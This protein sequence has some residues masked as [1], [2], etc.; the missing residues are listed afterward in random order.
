MKLVAE[1]GVG[2]VAAGVAKASADNILISGHDGGTGA[3]PLSSTKHAGAPWELGLAEAQ[4]TLL[5]NNLRDRVILRTDGGIRNGRDVVIAAILGAEQ[6]NFGTTAM[7]AM[8]CVYVRKCHLNTCPVGIATTDPKFRAKFKG[9]PEMVINYFDAVADEARRIMARLGVRSLDE[10]IGRPGFPQATPHPRSPESQHA[11][12]RRAAQGRRAGSGGAHPE[13]PWIPFL[14]RAP[15]TATTASPRPPSTSRSSPTSRR[16]V[17]IDPVDAP[18]Y[19]PDSVSTDMLDAIRLL[20]DRPPVALEY[21]VVNTDRNIGTRLSGR[22]AEI[23]GDRGL[24]Q[25]HDPPH[26]PRQRRPVASAVSS[27]P[28]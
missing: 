11:R 28:A 25:G 26:L 13:K 12:P 2:T 15:R 18:Q 1:S 7:I 5:L 19:G 3:S 14:A 23:H 9:T 6:Y 20:P 21:A 27:F 24:P 17:G 8:G 16:A 10:L 4:Q 22:I